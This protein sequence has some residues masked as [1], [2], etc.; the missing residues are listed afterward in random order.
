MSKVSTDFGFLVV[1][2]FCVMPAPNRQV[3][4]TYYLP[5]IH[6]FN[7]KVH[8]WALLLMGGWLLQ[9]CSGGKRE[10]TPDEKPTSAREWMTERESQETNWP[11]ID[12][13]CGR[14][15]F[16]RCPDQ[17]DTALL[18]VDR[19]K[20]SSLEKRGNQNLCRGWWIGLGQTLAY[21]EPMVFFAK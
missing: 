8:F 14:A 18:L 10:R 20:E 13:I 17:S 9:T 7:L 21:F 6:Y 12:L 11:I 16:D 19:W 1:I 2:W 5:R 15:E 4:A 3:H